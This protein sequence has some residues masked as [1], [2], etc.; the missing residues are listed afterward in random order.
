MRPLRTVRTHTRRARLRGTA[1]L[2][3]ALLVAACSADGIGS[4]DSEADASATDDD[5]EPDAQA[6]AEDWP[7]DDIRA[8]VVSGPGGG[9]DAA[10]RQLQPLLSDR[11]GVNIQVENEPGGSTAVGTTL[12]HR[13]EPDCNTVLV[14][15]IPHLIFTDLTQDVDY[16]FED[17][18]PVAQL[19]TEPA[20]FRVRNDAPWDTMQDLIDDARANPGQI[21][22]SVG[23]FTNNYYLS[24]LELQE[25]ADV[26]FNIVA[27]EGGG[28]AR[29]ALAAGEVELTS[30]GVYNSRNVEEDT[31]VLALH[32]HE[33]NW[34]EITDDAPPLHEALGLEADQV[35]Q[36]DSNYGL[37]VPQ[38]C[39]DEHPERRQILEDAVAD[40]IADPSYQE[41]LADLQEEGKSAFIPGDEYDQL[42]RE[43]YAEIEQVVAE[44]SDE[45]QQ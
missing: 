4:D 5:A 9:F 29:N 42:N 3:A 12:V 27:Y 13:S 19:T 40:A 45:F 24:L 11:L 16:T 6:G 15:G 23:F 17:F 38:A 39:E 44:R 28:D 7:T 31:R 26:E 18:H 20:L 25:L 14:T 21:R 30:A 34:G 35:S 8:V 22:A 32:Y 43:A 10:I 37:F 33:N 36:N 41:A 2:S 1:L